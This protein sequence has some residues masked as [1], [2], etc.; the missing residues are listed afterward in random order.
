[1]DAEARRA[2]EQMKA[3]PFKEKWKNFWYYYK[4]H[5]IISIFVLIVVGF[6][7][8]QCA[9]RIDYDLSISFYT[10]T[11]APNGAASE[12]E[13][14]LAEII[15]ETNNN[16]KRDVSVALYVADTEKMTEQYQAV[17]SK[18]M[19]EMA[20]GESMGFILDE[21]YRNITMES[22]EEISDAI[23]EISVIPEI[24]ERFM[25]KDGEK[26]YWITKMLYDSEKKNKESIAEHENA[27]RVEK[28]LIEMGATVIK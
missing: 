3:L 25:L 27:V 12:F 19:T 1:M 22:F 2:K 9:G 17:S 28:K 8:A 16:K 20:A 7:V 23:L 26:L 10:S 6:S 21:A 14:Q 24:K 18:L 13:K 4:K 15:E 5:V 11:G